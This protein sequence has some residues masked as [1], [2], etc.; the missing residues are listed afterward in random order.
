MKTLPGNVRVVLLT[1]VALVLFGAGYFFLVHKKAPTVSGPDQSPSKPP[2]S[3]VSLGGSTT[4]PETN[5]Y[6]N[7][8]GSK[9]HTTFITALQVAELL[10]V[11]QSKGPLTI[12][13]PSNLA[14]GKLSPEVVQSLFKPEHKSKLVELLNY[15]IVPGKYA[16][17]DLKDGMKLKTVEGSELVL[18]QKD[19]AWWINGTT[20]IEVADVFSTNGV[21]HTVSMVLTVPAVT[22]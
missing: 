21:A 8:K 3:G 19:G 22:P 18:S 13:A 9:D 10:P 16:S 1:L 11:L 15:H 6:S 7:L 5:L 20:K 14:F 2:V 12:F 4:K 17:T